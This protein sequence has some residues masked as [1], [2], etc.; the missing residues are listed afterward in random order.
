VLAGAQIVTFLGRGRKTDGNPVIDRKFIG[1][2]T[3]TQQGF[4]IPGIIAY[5][6]GTLIAWLTTVVVPFFIPPVNGIITAAAIYVIA[7]K[8]FP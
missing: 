6:L 8:T 4:H 1:G 2:D 7:K 5:A 3:F